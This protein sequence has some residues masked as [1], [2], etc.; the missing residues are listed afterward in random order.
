MAYYHSQQAGFSDAVREFQRA[1]NEAGFSAGEADGKWGP[2]T[3]QGW[4]NF[5]GGADFCDPDAL[6]RVMEARAKVLEL[7]QPEI[8]AEIDVRGAR[9]DRGKHDDVM[10][11]GLG[12]TIQ[13]WFDVDYETVEHP[14]SPPSFYPY[15][16][17]DIDF[18]PNLFECA[19]P[20]DPVSDGDAPL[21]PENGSG[22]EVVDK[23]LPW[24]VAKGEDGDY[25]QIDE[26]PTPATGS[27][28]DGCIY[29]KIGNI[30][31]Q[32]IQQGL[33]A[34]GLLPEYDA[35][36]NSSDDGVWG[37]QTNAAVNQYIQDRGL[38]PAQIRAGNLEGVTDPNIVAGLDSLDKIGALD[39]LWVGQDRFDPAAKAGPADSLCVD[40]DLCQQPPPAPMKMAGV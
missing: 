40:N 1:L 32:Q 5:R 38:D 7:L 13:D 36:G 6:R 14:T 23:P 30:A 27:L 24:F 20:D 10:N 34:V 8:D 3:R 16:K 39:R 31:T 28:E 17:E 2:N 18:V 15:V 12:K 9:H 19:E 21:V 33:I 22:T 37:P 25:Y 11:N 35:N 29:D 4:E 26:D